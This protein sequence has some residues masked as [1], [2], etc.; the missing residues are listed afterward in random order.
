MGNGSI[1][2]EVSFLSFFQTTEYHY[3]QIDQKA[4]NLQD[5]SEEN[6]KFEIVSGPFGF[7]Q[8]NKLDKRAKQVI[9]NLTL[10]YIACD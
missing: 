10:S 5:H 9:M 2:I 6:P 8:A 4:T 1:G 7:K 3:D